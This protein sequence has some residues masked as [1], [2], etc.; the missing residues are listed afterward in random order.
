MIRDKRIEMESREYF[1]EG[2]S[3]SNK[4]EQYEKLN[5]EI[6][7]VKVMLLDLRA[8]QAGVELPPP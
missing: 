1:K 5:K 7:S 2:E 3:A 8:N 4:D 6:D